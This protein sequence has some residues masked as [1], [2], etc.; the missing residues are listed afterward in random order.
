MRAEK[1][2]TLAGSS[3]AAGV[4]LHSGGETR[5]TLRPAPEGSGLI[6]RRTDLFGADGAP[7]SAAETSI[8]ATPAHVVDTRLG[9]T[10]ANAAG[11]SVRTV[12]HLMAA[13]SLAGVDHAIVEVAGPEIPIFDGSAAPFLQLIEKA[14]VRRLAAP[15][16][17]IVI[18]TPLRVEDGDRFVELLPATGRALEVSIDFP[19][20]AIGRQSVSF[21]LEHAAAPRARI[22]AARTFCALRD[23]EAMR[24]A[25]LGK[26][27]SLDN[28]VVV[29]GDRLLNTTGLR[30]A[31]EFAL[32]KALDLIGDL[33]L[34]G[35]P[36]D[37]LMRAHKPGH[38]LN[39]RL[40]AVL[41]AKREATARA[42]AGAVSDPARLRA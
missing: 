28:A 39:T 32:H 11:V 19:D 2:S 36:V 14:G 30:D 40:A 12:E 41:A 4:G 7:L 17:S 33:Y 8:P 5:L 25:G 38:D 13:F 29:D 35:A 37:G 6:F 26:G 42:V 24:A 9:V 34:A 20:A 23:V 1:Q 22:A 16:E 21:T 18:Q 10:L 15:R 27:G 3:A 31:K